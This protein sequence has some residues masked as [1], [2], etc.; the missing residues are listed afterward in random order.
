M[1]ESQTYGFIIENVP[2]FIDARPKIAH[3]VLKN[4]DGYIRCIG[5]YIR[6]ELEEMR[7]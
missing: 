2:N 4:E 3:D 6:D 7:K 1:K 5:E